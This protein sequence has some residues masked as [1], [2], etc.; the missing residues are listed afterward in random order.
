LFFLVHGFGS[1]LIILEFIYLFVNQQPATSDEQPAAFSG[2]K[3][4]GREVISQ[5]EKERFF[6]GENLVDANFSS[7]I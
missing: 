5:F 4:K 3:G 1:W 2:R 6:G 7:L